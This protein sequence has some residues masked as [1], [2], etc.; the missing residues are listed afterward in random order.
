MERSVAEQKLFALKEKINLYN[1]HYYVLDNPL[2]S[3]Q[4]YDRLYR[5]LITIEELYPDLISPDSPSQRI[6]G[7]PLPY[8]TKVT[9]QVPMLSLANAFNEGDLRDFDR[10]VRIASNQE[11]I[12]YMVELK[13]DGLAISLRYENGLLV[14]GATRGDGEVGEDITQNLKTIKSIPL[15]LAEPLTL[16]VRGE[17]YMPKKEFEKINRI[18]EENGEQPLANP[19]NAAAGSLR[20][21][22]PKLAKERNLDVFIYNLAQITGKRFNTHSETLDYLTK[23]HFKVNPER[24]IAQGIEEVLRIVEMWQEKRREL[25]YEIDGL[26]IKVDSLDLQNSLGF[27][28]KSPRWAIAYKFPAEEV[29]TVIEEVEFNV[30]RTGVVTPTAILKP[31]SLA[32]TIV[33]R[34]TLHN[35][36]LIKEKDI[37]LGDHVLV[38]KAGEIIPEV[39]GVVRERRTGTEKVIKMPTTCPACQHNLVR[40][41]GEVALRCINPA[42]PA[43]I[44]EGIIHFVS[45]DAMNIEGLGEKVIEQLY[46]NHLIEN[47]ADLYTLTKEQLLPLERMGEKSVDNLLKAIEQSKENSLEKLIFALGIKLVG[48]K[49]AKVLAAHFQTLENL[50]KASNFDL[51]EIAEIG[52]KMAESI[53]TFFNDPKTQELLMRLKSYGVNTEYKGAKNISEKNNPFYNKVVVLTGT[54]S[55]M[56]RNEATKILEELGAKV[57]NSISKT[58]DY[59]IVGEKAGSKLEKAEKLNISIL[60]EEKWLKMINRS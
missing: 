29:I 16:E 34:A 41:K 48:E 39:V 50:E 38:K 19:R 60:N 51:E 40:L 33:K 43:Q 1:Y 28:A 10:K 56:G 14:Q 35:E 58:T 21:L 17:A 12:N 5:E 23:I 2:I 37:R 26:V 59:L 54:L 47:S 24:R 46:A 27:T 42:C 36:D 7:G 53:V 8:F 13:I 25:P 30:G 57:T 18:R 31:V 11:L 45:R 9:H 6:G 44:L 49:A 20:Q 22:D 32:G 3:D 52:P 4:E 55:S 15:R